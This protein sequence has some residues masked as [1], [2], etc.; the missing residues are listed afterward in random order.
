MISTPVTSS[1]SACSLQETMETESMDGYN[2]TQQ[3][4]RRAYYLSCFNACLY[5]NG[6]IGIE[7]CGSMV[8]ATVSTWTQKY[9]NRALLTKAIYSIKNCASIASN[10]WYDS[11]S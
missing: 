4:N 9:K 6:Y 5:L 7:L 8:Y 3:T 1:A 2:A 10:I 11:M